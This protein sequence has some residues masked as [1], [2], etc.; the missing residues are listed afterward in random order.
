VECERTTA[1]LRHFGWI[2]SQISSP[3]PPIHNV[4]DSNANLPNIS[5]S[6]SLY[7]SLETESQFLEKD[8][9]KFIKHYVGME[10]TLAGIALRYN[11]SVQY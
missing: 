11:V 4:I 1:L 2:S 5:S 8:G 9:M 10:E 7:P 6:G 3:T